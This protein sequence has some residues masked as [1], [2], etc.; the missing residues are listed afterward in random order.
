[1]S[2]GDANFQNKSNN[3]DSP[4]LRD[5]ATHLIAKDPFPK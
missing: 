5:I 3:I 4:Q 1:M 2:K